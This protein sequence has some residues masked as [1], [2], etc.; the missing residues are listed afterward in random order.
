MIHQSFD[1]KTG[2]GETSKKISNLNEV[3]A[4]EI[5]KPMIRKTQEIDQIVYARFKD[6]MGS[7]QSGR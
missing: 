1:K 3:L 5:H 2:S 6:E 4:Q 7:L